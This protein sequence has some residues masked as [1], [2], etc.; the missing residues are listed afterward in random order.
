ME[1]QKLLPV[2]LEAARTL[3]DQHQLIPIIGCSEQLPADLYQD[4]IP[5]ESKWKSISGQTHRLMQHAKLALVAS[6]TATLELGY[7]QTP[8]IVLYRVSPVTYYF[9]KM[10]IKIPNIALANI[11]LGKTVVPEFIQK[12]LNPTQIAAAAEQ[13][14]TDH[15]AYADV[16]KALGGVRV[17][18]GDPGASQRAAAV[19]WD[20]MKTL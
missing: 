16:K 15:A 19:I 20:Y 12:E 6:G 10:V 17:G 14:L 18:L 8:M 11:V 3:T 13:L 5:K 9:G 2:M 7:L 1:V 4:I